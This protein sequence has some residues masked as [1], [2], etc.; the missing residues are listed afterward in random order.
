MFVN[1]K[2]MLGKGDGTQIGQQSLGLQKK[3]P[4]TSFAS[5]LLENA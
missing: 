5:P 2:I 1:W 4:L 3:N